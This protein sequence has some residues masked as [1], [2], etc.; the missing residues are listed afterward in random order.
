M[1]IVIVMI[2]DD[3]GG[4]DCSKFNLK[5]PTA[6][7]KTQCFYDSDSVIDLIPSPSST[8]FHQASTSSSRSPM[9]RKLE[10]KGKAV[11]AARARYFYDLPVL[12]LNC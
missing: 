9:Q 6:N 3:S 12:F 11:N 2:T 5:P 10:D 8:L 4:G 1:M 7:S